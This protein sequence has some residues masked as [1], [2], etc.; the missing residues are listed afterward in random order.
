MQ[1]G[2]F[3]WKA[4]EHGWPTESKTILVARRDEHRANI[5][6]GGLLAP[7]VAVSSVRLLTAMACKLD[8]D[9]CHFDIEQAFAQSGLR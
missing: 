9:L 3:D 5:D 8:L 2:V 1:C 4:D 7:T 6:F